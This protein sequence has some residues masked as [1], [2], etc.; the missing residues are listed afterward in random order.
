MRA[1]SSEH[2]IAFERSFEGRRLVVLVTRLPLLRT[3]GAAPWAVGEIWR[4][5]SQELPPG[6]YRSLFTNETLDS[7][8]SVALEEVFA[9]LPVA[10]LLSEC[11][12]YGGV[13]PSGA[14]TQ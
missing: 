5:E 4:D 10:A 14:A 6:R 12:A 1:P 13:Q 8:G 2:V 9:D 7:R 3:A 11:A